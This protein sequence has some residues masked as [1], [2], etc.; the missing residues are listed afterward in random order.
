M[1]QDEAIKCRF[2]GELLIPPVI[3]QPRA[4]WYFSDISVFVAFL[5]VGPLMLPLVWWNPRYSSLVKILVTVVILIL[6]WLMYRSIS[7]SLVKLQ[8]MYRIL[9][10]PEALP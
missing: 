10:N 9:Q 6:T 4:L 8:E 7:A 1:I 3:K 2:C 5:C